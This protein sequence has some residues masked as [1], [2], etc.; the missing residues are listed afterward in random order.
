MPASRGRAQRPLHSV[1][2]GD[3]E[4]DYWMG[5][6]VGYLGGCFS[7]SNIWSGWVDQR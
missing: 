1:R 2:M 5:T 4:R 7:R 3:L 6:E